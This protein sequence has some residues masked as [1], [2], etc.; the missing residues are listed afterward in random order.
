MV[1]KEGLKIWERETVSGTGRGRGGT[2]TVAAAEPDGF[3]SAARFDAGRRKMISSN[4]SLII[5]FSGQR[6]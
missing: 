4:S 3:R 2:F 6:V 5:R 1:R